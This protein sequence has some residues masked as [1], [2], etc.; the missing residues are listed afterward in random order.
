M[1]EI[2]R[3][4]HSLWLKKLSV[5]NDPWLLFELTGHLPVINESPS[6]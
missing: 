2:E 4:T 5:E 3:K 1:L 6:N